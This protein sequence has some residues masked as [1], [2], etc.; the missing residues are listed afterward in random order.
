MTLETR[1]RIALIVEYDGTGYRG[2][3][4]QS[5][6]P[7]VQGELERG[8]QDL[9]G[10][11][12]KTHGAGRTDAGAHAWGQ[13]VALT[14]NAGYPAAMYPRALNGV[15]PPDIRVTAAAEVGLDFDP[16]RS[17]RR[18]LYRYLVL[19]Q[20]APSALWGRF[21]YHVWAELDLAAMAGAAE[22]FRGVRDY[23]AFCR[24]SSL[25]RRDTVREVF[26]VKVWRQGQVVAVDMTANAFLPQQARR[27][28]GT[29]VRVGQGRLSGSAVLPLLEGTV[30]VSGGPALPACGLYLMYVV[31][32]EG[33]LDISGPRGLQERGEPWPGLLD[34]GQG[35]P[36]WQ[37]T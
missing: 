10:K 35:E 30:E 1:R 31:Y 27:I 15:L 34:P 14:T 26:S 4:T 13:V 21:A 8:L 23:R 9:L 28:A 29:L 11:Y 24:A 6:R 37:Q 12:V 22:A 25:R 17:A 5:K 3:Q 36:S 32:P 7:T 18:R 33:I 16:R 20:P 19:N 2:F